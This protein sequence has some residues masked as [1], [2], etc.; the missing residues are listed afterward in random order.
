MAM[1]DLRLP[2]KPTMME[3][4]GRGV[5]NVTLAVSE[6]L[7]SNYQILQE[8]GP[9]Y[10]YTVGLTQGASRM[11][12]DTGVGALEIATFFIPT[13]SMKMPAHDSGQVDPVPPADLKDN[14]Y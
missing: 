1:A 14:W 2:P 13:K 6:I 8:K 4:L 5:A 12:M 3:K 7:D 11:V 10:A 9:T